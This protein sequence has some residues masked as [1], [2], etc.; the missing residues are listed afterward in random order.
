MKYRDAFKSYRTMGICRGVLFGMQL[1]LGFIDKFDALRVTA[2]AVVACA[3]LVVFLYDHIMMKQV[4]RFLED[5]KSSVVTLDEMGVEI[6]KYLDDNSID[7]IR[8]E[9]V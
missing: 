1:W 6:N 8:I 7:V 9:R 3:A 2:M 4:R 5:D